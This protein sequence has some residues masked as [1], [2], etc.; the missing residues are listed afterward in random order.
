MCCT[1]MR[2]IFQRFPCI[3]LEV[4][5]LIKLVF[6]LELSV[7]SLE[8]V[9]FGRVASYINMVNLKFFWLCKPVEVNV[10]VKN[11]FGDLGKQGN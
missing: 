6:K 4:K 8:H 2:L 1:C 11:L 10:I 9:N 3:Y 5:S 7:L